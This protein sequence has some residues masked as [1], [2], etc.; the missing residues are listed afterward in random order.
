M[1]RFVKSMLE[2][3]LTLLLLL[4]MSSA[5][6]GIAHRALDKKT[7]KIG[8]QPSA[9]ADPVWTQAE[10]KTGTAGVEKET[11]GKNEE[12]EKK[13]TDGDVKITESPVGGAEASLQSG[14]VEVVPA[15]DPEADD[16][17]GKERLDRLAKLSLAFR[18]SAY[19]MYKEREPMEGELPKEKAEEVLRE[20]LDCL[21]LGF[22]TAGWMPVDYGLE[23]EFHLVADPYSEELA[24]WRIDYSCTG[25]IMSIYLDSRTGNLVRLYLFCGGELYEPSY[26]YGGGITH[27]I[28]SENTWPLAAEYMIAYL[29]MARDIRFVSE[30]IS[31]LSG[32][33]Y[34]ADIG[35][36]LSDRS[37][38]WQWLTGEGTYVMTVIRDDEGSRRIKQADI[39]FSTAIGAKAVREKLSDRY[40]FLRYSVSVYD[41]TTEEN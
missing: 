19:G 16:P 21:S 20:V 27:L 15:S 12:A 11:A 37:A 30:P 6:M 14:Y 33:I 39:I 41:G 13:L 25:A 23:P 40:S 7:E 8:R 29:E 31:R 32:R 9:A 24:L 38:L 28:G 10:Q 35:W 2:I 22:G 18:G 5:G 36:K 26:H 1:K 34:D 4:V 17:A 3:V